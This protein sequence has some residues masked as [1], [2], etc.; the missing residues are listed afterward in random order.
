MT[1]TECPRKESLLRCGSLYVKGPI[2]RR[3]WSQKD[4]PRHSDAVHSNKSSKAQ[5]GDDIH[6]ETTVEGVWSILGKTYPDSVLS[7]ETGTTLVGDNASLNIDNITTPRPSTDSI[8]HSI[9][10]RNDADSRRSSDSTVTIHQSNGDSNTPNFGPIHETV[11]PR[12]LL[13]PFPIAS[14]QLPGVEL[15]LPA[16]F[17]SLDRYFQ[18]Q[19]VCVGSTPPH[20]ETRCICIDFIENPD[21]YW[22]S[23][24]GISEHAT[25]IISSG[26]KDD[27]EEYRDCFGNTALHLVAARSD[28]HILL[29]SLE[30]ARYT[31]ATNS[32]GQ[33]F[34]HMLRR[35]WFSHGAALLFQLIEQA[36]AAGVDVSAQD[37]YG[38]TLAHLALRGILNGPAV[39][40]I[41]QLFD[42]T[43]LSK[44]DAFG[45]RPESPATMQTE[46]Q[47]APSAG[48]YTARKPPVGS[49]AINTHW[50]LDPDALYWW[51]GAVGEVA[52]YE[53]VLLDNV[54][55]ALKS[56]EL[57]DCQ[58]RS[59]LHCLA[60]AISARMRCLPEGLKES[61]IMNTLDQSRMY[62]SEL[63]TAGVDVNA[64]NLYGNTALMDFV[65][66][67]PELPTEIDNWQI[68]RLLQMLID[69]GA[70]LESRNR[71]GET[72]LLVAARYGRKTALKMLVLAGANSKARDSLGR[73]STTIIKECLSKSATGTKTYERWE[74]CLEALPS[75]NN[76]YMRTSNSETQT[77]TATNEWRLDR[78]QITSPGNPN[79]KAT[80]TE[81]RDIPVDFTISVLE[82]FRGRTI[83]KES[84]EIGDG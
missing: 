83:D 21:E 43:T 26:L 19:P 31:A 62:V 75:I 15:V 33:T 22:T 67:T 58:G 40:E 52:A 78:Y 53:R 68:K 48:E 1:R 35:D 79:D 27:D 12:E 32:G 29:R 63:L 11:L 39:E 44:R 84:H 66:L 36:I 50:G 51:T 4:N 37:V 73:D 47:K 81:Y 77:V 2:S 30:V 59:G 57:E 14:P 76:V 38:Q 80:Q 82:E 25:S 69:P 41:L 13:H 6:G 28:P 60:V 56:P 16:A 46:S 54:S 72:A 7:Q 17:L 5:K 34:L 20:D 70:N 65:A 9:G 24:A 18:R 71:L 64:Y 23:S 74:K 45:L 3:K 61:V 55:Q 49:A 10:D 42:K 8:T